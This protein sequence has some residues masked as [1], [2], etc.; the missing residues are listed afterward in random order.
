MRLYAA[1]SP[2]YSSGD[3]HLVIVETAG[4]QMLDIPFLLWP[5]RI[6]CRVEVPV[7]AD[8][9]NNT[10]PRSNITLS[11]W[12]SLPPFL[13]SP[14]TQSNSNIHHFTEESFISNGPIFICQLK[15]SNKFV[16]PRSG[17]MLCQLI[18]MFLW[19]DT[20]SITISPLKQLQ[21]TLVW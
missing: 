18:L 20:L 5:C 2:I 3:C 7:L 21:I 11:I 9:V 16:V 6:E 8:C 12:R 10:S 1:A 15:L 13:L 19:P 14:W 17:K 4:Q